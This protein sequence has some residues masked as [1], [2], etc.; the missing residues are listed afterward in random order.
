M[1]P[2]LSLPTLSLTLT[3]T[4]FP[5]FSPSPLPTP[6]STLLSHFKSLIPH[7]SISNSSNSDHHLWLREEQRWIREE[8]R[9]LREEQRW[10]RERDSLLREIAELKLEVQALQRRVS[11]HEVSSDAVVNV[12]TLLQVLKEKNLVLDSESSVRRLVLEHN[13]NENRKE[14]EPEEVIEHE[15]EVVVIE[16][17]V[18]A[19]SSSSS[20]TVKKRT[21]L[22]KG[23]EGEQ[24]QE[25]QEALL[26]LGFY[27]GEDEMEYFSFDS[28]TDRAVKTWQAAVGVPEDGIMTHELLERLYLE[29]ATNDAG[30]GTDNKK[31]APVLLKEV[32]NG[33]AIASVTEISEGQQKVVVKDDSGVQVSSHGRVFLLGEN[34]WE[35]PSRLVATPGVDRT[36]NKDGTTKCL[37]CR[38]EGQLLCT[39][40]DGSGEP[41]IEPQFMEWVGETTK[42]PYC[43]GLGYTPCDLCGGKATV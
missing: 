26:K 22:R 16:E 23:S 7:C 28:G 13:E 25:L 33:A 12:K 10:A 14:E 32:E 36:K 42:C 27:S 1:S 17:S 6:S 11:S 40:C 19:S 37:Q 21:T 3:K 43:E 30:N 39:E 2:S 5:L 18:S 24:V 38:G 35:E 9:W 34:R 15:K 4:H 29:I 41:N 20:A 31:S 8:Q